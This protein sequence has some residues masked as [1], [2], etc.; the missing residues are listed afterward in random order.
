MT[1][2]P[3]LRTAR[4]RRLALLALVATVVVAVPA[5]GDEPAEKPKNP[6]PTAA[7]REAAR[8]E[9]ERAGIAFT[10]ENFLALVAK[11]DAGTVATFVRAGIDPASAD[12]R[13]R[14]ALWIAVERRQLATLKALLAGGIEPK[15]ANAP[16]L[17]A[18]KT[19]VFEAVDT[20]E[21]EYVEVLAQAGADAKTANDYGVPPLAEAAR[22][23]NLA[24]CK[25]LITAGADPNHAPG[26]FPLLFGPVVE[27]H[28]EVVRFLLEQ[29]A[30]LGASKQDLL[31]AAKS[32]EM[33]ALLSA[34][35]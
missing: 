34:N 32:E 35:E 15:G 24:M 33:K 23:G 6:A 14:T 29:G 1:P 3:R 5:R 17:D 10:P 12:G 18:G 16:A 28:L 20:G 9:L 11:G 26:G 31:D 27:G 7:E 2:T 30:K 19:L 8:A 25:A 22:V 21:A 4:F 13:G